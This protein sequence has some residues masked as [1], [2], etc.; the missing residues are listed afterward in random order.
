MA[1]DWDKAFAEAHLSSGPASSGLTVQNRKPPHETARNIF[2]DDETDIMA[3]AKKHGYRRL[4]PY[5]RE[6]APE[7]KAIT[8]FKLK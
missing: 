3:A 6:G 5:P 7:P 2:E 1:I 8:F 4:T